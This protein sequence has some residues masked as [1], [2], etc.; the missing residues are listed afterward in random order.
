MICATRMS[1][2]L[3]VNHLQ[4]RANV[5]SRSI[6]AKEEGGEDLCSNSNGDVEREQAC[7]ANAALTLWRISLRM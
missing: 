6:E 3:K 1:R 2:K 4:I 5:L 7:D